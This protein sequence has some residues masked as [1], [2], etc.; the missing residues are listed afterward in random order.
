MDVKVTYG[1]DRSNQPQTFT[2]RVAVEAEVSIAVYE[3]G[4]AS[5]ILPVMCFAGAF[6]RW[7]RTR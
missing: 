7:Q 2:S 5:A 1:S 6:I 4:L 3:M